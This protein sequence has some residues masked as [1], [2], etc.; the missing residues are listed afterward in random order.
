MDFLDKEHIDPFDTSDPDFW[1][2]IEHLARYQYAEFKLRRGGLSKGR[3]LDIGC[4]TGYGMQVLEKAGFTCQGVDYDPEAVN[5]AR[6]NDLDVLEAD[7]DT[8]ALSDHLKP[9]N[10]NAVCAFEVIEHVNRP[11]EVINDIFS[12]LKPGGWFFASVP[13]PKFERVKDGEP[14]NPYHHHA[15]EQDEFE[16]ILEKAGF[17]VVETLG[18]SLTNRLFNRERNLHKGGVIPQLE[19]SQPHFQTPQAIT[20]MAHILAWPFHEQ[21]EKSYS[22]IF[23]CQKPQ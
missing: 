20:H 1:M 9:A 13:N 15:F 6:Q 19:F 22:F 18:Q 10:F 11:Q 17:N 12:L 16:A 8:S 5:A 3:V 4:G 14:A 23:V 21:I 7:M 2:K